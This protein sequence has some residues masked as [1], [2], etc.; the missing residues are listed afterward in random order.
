M[1]KP[2]NDG[3]LKHQDGCLSYS[4]FIYGLL[5]QFNMCLRDGSSHAGLCGSSNLYIQSVIVLFDYL[6]L[7]YNIA[8]MHCLG[9]NAL[10]AG[11]RYAFIS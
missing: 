7:S 9:C 11:V 8:T 10:R 2:L 1:I 6:S 4:L 5:T 3:S